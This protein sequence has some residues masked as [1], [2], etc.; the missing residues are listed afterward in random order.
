MQFINGQTGYL[1]GESLWK[2]TNLGTNWY[3][4]GS[5]ANS[6]KMFFI[7]ENTGFIAS[8]SPSGTIAKTTNGG[9][10]FTIYNFSTNISVQGIFFVNSLTGHVIST[11]QIYK[12][13]NGGVNWILQTANIT[14]PFYRSIYFVSS[15]TGFVAGIS[16]LNYKGFIGKTTTGGNTFIT[17]LSSEVP[18]SFS[19]E[20]NYP[21]PFNSRANIQFKVLST[22]FVKLLVYDISGREVRTLVNE[23]IQAGLYQ[24]SFITEGLTSG[25][26]L[27][28]MISGDFSETKKL[29][30]LK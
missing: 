15:D 24:I 10:N 25:I 21:N 1:G 7:D 30:L 27:Y 12:S 5:G 28:R 16:N 22:N 8:S 2:T 26:Y 9:V 11:N 19:L 17:K 13:T 14:L 23:N 3:Q 4:P 29:L 18:Q 20:Q 6:F